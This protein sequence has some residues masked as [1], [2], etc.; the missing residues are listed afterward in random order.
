[1]WSSGALFGATAAEA[2]YVTVD[3]SNNPV[4]E[5]ELGRVVVEIGVAPV[6]PAEFVVVRIGLWAGG[7]QVQEG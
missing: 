1:V 6:R 2:F 5:Q 4:T 3:R 7:A